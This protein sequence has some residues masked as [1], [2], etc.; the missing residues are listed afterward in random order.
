MKNFPFT[1]GGH[2]YWYSRSIVCTNFVFCQFAGHWYVLAAQRGYDCTNPALWNVPGGFLDHD[3]T[4]K[5]CAERETFEETGLKTTITKLYEIKDNPKSSAKQ[6]VVFSYYTNLG[7]V[8]NLPSINSNYCELNEVLAVRWIPIDSIHKYK[9]IKGHAS[10]IE[11]IYK[12]IINP[13]FS[14]RRWIK[15]LW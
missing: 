10:K 8:K 15:S 7:K 6:H 11:K 9:W 13:P 14:W 12:E 1:R 4:L 3:E 2:E 5:Q